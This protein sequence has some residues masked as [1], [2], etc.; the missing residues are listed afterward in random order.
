MAESDLPADI[1]N[2]RYF[3]RQSSPAPGADR[4]FPLF[5]QLPR[6]LRLQIWAWH[7]PRRRFLRILLEE[8]V[9]AQHDGSEPEPEA[10]YLESSS[11]SGSGPCHKL[12]D[13]DEWA[14]IFAEGPGKPDMEVM[15]EPGGPSET[16]TLPSSGPTAPLL[17]VTFLG[18]PSPA[19]PALRLVCREARDAHNSVYSIQLPVLARIPW[20]NGARDYTTTRIVAHLNPELDILSLQTP[21]PIEIATLNLLP[22]F[23]HHLLQHDLSPSPLRFGVRHLCVDLRHLGSDYHHGADEARL[24]GPAPLA[25]HVLA[26]VRLAV[27][28][29]RGLYLRLTTASHLE[30]R[31]MSGPFASTRSLPWYNAS[32][33]V[34]PGVS[35]GFLG[36]V[37]PVPGGDPRLAHPEGAADLRQ[38][39]IGNQL[40]PSLDVWAGLERAWGVP[41]GEAG[42]RVRALVGLDA[43]GWADRKDRSLGGSS[44]GAYLREERAAW[45]S[46]MDPA[47]EMGA[48]LRECFQTAQQTFLPGP[49]GGRPPAVA[50]EEWIS[51]REPYTVVGFWLINPE[52]LEAAETTGYVGK[53]I[54]NLSER[55]VEDI[56]LWVFG[57]HP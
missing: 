41:T 38:V 56:E 22:F 45:Q 47:L 11:H 12:G 31:V 17:R 6:E 21:N 33:P 40:R 9:E 5:A 42:T 52:V 7:L 44:L 49:G 19:M 10:L 20:G 14:S 23:L 3:G 32:V 54:V 16:E 1:F 48:V 50:P 2:S 28:H 57:G 30:P 15:R 13:G 29:L 26:S 4:E 39:W 24:E 35:W 18:A 37:E 43:E 36:T 55:E 8:G 53:K 25:P 34:L 27:S 51:R 46:L